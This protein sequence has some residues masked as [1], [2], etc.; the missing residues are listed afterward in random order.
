MLCCRRLELVVG[1]LLGLVLEV[2]SRL[3]DELRLRLHV[4]G[5]LP[6][7]LDL[8]LVH[9]EVARVIGS[10]V[11]FRGLLLA[12]GD[13]GS[14]VGAHLLEE[15]L[16]IAILRSE[17]GAHWLHL[18]VVTALCRLLL[19]RLFTLRV[20]VGE[21]VLISTKPSF[22]IF[23][24]IERDAADVLEPLRQLIRRSPCLGFRLNV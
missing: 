10:W 5:D 16:L 15:V 24:D 23:L 18:G 17:L 20:E 12:T 19:I 6:A 3:V 1:R 22:D 2:C 21:H 8:S 4:R 9:L 14:R 11:A 7:L 13:E